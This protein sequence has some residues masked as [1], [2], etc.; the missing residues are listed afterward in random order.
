MTSISQGLPVKLNKVK[1]AW[2]A[3]DQIIEN[4]ENKD[5]DFC[6]GSIEFYD[7]WNLS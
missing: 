2:L 6:I 7:S 5:F 1:D 4:I 3:L